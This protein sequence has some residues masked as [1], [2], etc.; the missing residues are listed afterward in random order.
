MN[1][2]FIVAQI[3]GLI[4]ICFEFASYQIKDKTKYFL[5][6]GIGSFFWMTMFI[7]IGLATGMSTQLSLIVAGTYSTIR[8]LVFF[9][10]FSKNTPE[11]KEAGLI[12][13]L[14]MILVALVAGV[15]AILNSPEQV[16]WLHALGLITALGFVIGQ[17]LPGVHYVR[18][19]VVF[20]AVVVLLTQTPLNILYGDFRWNI[21]GI[22]IESAKIISV[23]VFYVRYASEPKRPGLQF[24][25]P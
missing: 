6:T 15:V 8:N 1:T 5:V 18:I 24:A 16:R 19:A 4:T 7:A 20:Y 12:F 21:M 11:S 14:V 23:V 25:K 9:R 22:L 17:Y 13:L 10:I 2:W 3:L